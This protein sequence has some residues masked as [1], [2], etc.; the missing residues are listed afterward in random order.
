[1]AYM[2]VAF[3]KTYDI[4]EELIINSNQTALHIRP[5]TD[6]TYDIKGVKDVKSLGKDDKCQITYTVSSA[7]SG[8]LLPL[9]LI[10]QGKPLLL[11]LKTPGRWQLR[12]RAGI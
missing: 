8:D 7:A 3:V 11:S 12:R 1:M 5:S 10:F 2:I 4:P 6:Q 9:Q